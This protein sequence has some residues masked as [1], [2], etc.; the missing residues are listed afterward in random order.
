MIGDNPAMSVVY[1]DER[2]DEFN[3]LF[4]I[5][6]I[7]FG[8]DRLGVVTVSGQLIMGRQGATCVE[9]I[10]E[11]GRSTEDAWIAKVDWS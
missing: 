8:D 9:V 10:L 3:L 11:S 4:D 2:G 1:L 6:E 7:T 5:D